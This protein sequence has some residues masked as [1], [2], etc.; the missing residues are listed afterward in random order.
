[1]KVLVGLGN[2]G[3]SYE[4][5]RHNIGSRILKQFA[6]QEGMIFKKSLSL[7]A[8]WGK[9]GHSQEE[10]RV[11]LP[12]NYMNLSGKV[13]LRCSKRWNFPL[14]HMLVVM[15]DLHLPLGELRIRPSGSDGGQ[16][17][18]RSIIEVLGTEKFPRL[19]I[20]IHPV[21]NEI[22]TGAF[23]SSWEEFVLSSFSRKEEAA[24]EKMVNEATECCRVWIE[25]GIDACMNRF[26]RKGSS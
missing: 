7:E 16:K 21:R 14:T 12:Q 2:P 15:D 1:M 23:E 11:V 8:L 6:A 10:I 5:T 24:V 26:N 3:R 13:V 17:G 4:K 20:G 22:S 25:K 19:R 9:G 18:L